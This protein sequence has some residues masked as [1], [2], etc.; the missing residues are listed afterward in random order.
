MAGNKEVTSSAL[1]PAVPNPKRVSAGR[2]NRA[3]RKGLTPEGLAR[4][5]QAALDN[6]PWKLSTGPR[7]PA[8]KARS[9]LNGKRGQQGPLSINQIRVELAEL[10]T[11]EKEMREGRSLAA[12]L[13]DQFCNLGG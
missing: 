10:R 9:A 1:P 3:K 8:G 12:C 4:L 13:F 6:Q 5:R 7:T 11:L 2:R